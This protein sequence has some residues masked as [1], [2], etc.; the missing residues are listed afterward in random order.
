MKYRTTGERTALRFVAPLAGAWI[1]IA[2]HA[3]TKETNPVAPL[4]GA[5]IEIILQKRDLLIVN[6]A[7]LAGAW[8]EI[9]LFIIKQITIESLPS[10]E[11]G[12]K[13]HCRS[14]NKIS[15]CRSPRGSVD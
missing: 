2:I 4:A 10:R 13:L 7:P 12:L 5:W 1:E 9:A 3:G 8:I 14:V 11:R 6:V 15:K